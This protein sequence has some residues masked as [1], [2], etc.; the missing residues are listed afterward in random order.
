MPTFKATG[1]DGQPIEF[2]WYADEPPTPEDI[3]AIAAARNQNFGGRFVNRLIQN[4]IGALDSALTML[5]GGGAASKL[6]HGETPSLS[7]AIPGKVLGER[8]AANLTEKASRIPNDPSWVGRAG[9]VAALPLEAISPISP[10][11][12]GDAIGTGDFGSAGADI[13]SAA[14]L[15]KAGKAM[16]R[17]MPDTS[18][19]FGPKAAPV[20]EGPT[21]KF[22]DVAPGKSGFDAEMGSAVPFE[23]MDVPGPT[24]MAPNISLMIDE[25]A[26]AKEA[27][28]NQGRP[29]RGEL[30]PMRTALGRDAGPDA[31]G[32]IDPTLPQ[33][34]LDII[35]GK[36][37][38][39]PPERGLPPSSGETFNLGPPQE[40]PFSRGA[41]RLGPGDQTLMANPRYADLLRRIQ[42]KNVL[43]ALQR[44]TQQE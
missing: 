4:G 30:P 44:A 23:R 33:H 32:P 5:P 20:P 19:A 37:L 10:T 8:M 34:Y 3:A 43:S 11:D 18:G 1:P 9:R 40:S 13:L 15:G 24:P 25:I 42:Q 36:V 41:I 39:V 12:V 26:R 14:L 31:S 22:I 35:E 2:D 6:F 21:A 27:I 17:R 29:M 38:R 28:A 16:G 7:D